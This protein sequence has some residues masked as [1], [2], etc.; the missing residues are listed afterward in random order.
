[1]NIPRGLTA[2][3]L[4][5]ALAQDGY[6]LKRTRGSHHVYSQPGGR[7]AGP[8]LVYAQKHVFERVSV[9]RDHEILT[10]ALRHG[11]GQI[12]HSELNGLLAAK[13]SS[14]AVLRHANELATA[15]TLQGEREMIETIN[16]GIGACGP[17]AEVNNFV[18][19]DRIRPEQRR[20]IE[21]V[22]GSRDRIVN[23]Q[24]AAGTGKTATLQELKRTLSESGRCLLAVA[25]TMSAVEELQKVGFHDAI[26]LERL[27]QD[28][29]SSAAF[30]DSVL[31]LDEAGMVF[32][33]QMAELLRQ[34]ERHATRGVFCGDT[35]QIQSVEAGD[36]LRILANESRL[37][38]IA[39]T[40]VQR[41]KPKDY[42]AAIQELRQNPERGFDNLEA[43]GA[44]QEIPWLDRAATIAKAYADSNSSTRSVLVVCPHSRGDSPGDGCHSLRSQTE[45]RVGEECFSHQR[46]FLELDSRSKDRST[47]FSTRTIPWVPSGGKRYFEE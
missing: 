39:L 19:S 36:A 15:E 16:R 18:P 41:Q 13:E 1:L 12:G 28:S 45:F 27:L 11:R 7:D 6:A 33:R 29:K 32:S 40:E 24:G 23:V 35:R 20:V 2:R 38:S 42:R 47:Q 10:E 46:C 9:A 37:K 26:T 30:K 17:L 44:V 4:T 31:I 34:M 8:S 5:R 21:F 3:D 25:P 43:I 22:L 14:G